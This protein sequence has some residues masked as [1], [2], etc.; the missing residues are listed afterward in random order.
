LCAGRPAAP[1]Y[2]PPCCEKRRPSFRKT[3]LQLAK[4]VNGSGTLSLANKGITNAN[5]I[6]ALPAP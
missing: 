4:D 5:L 6:N 3:L 1:A 2:E